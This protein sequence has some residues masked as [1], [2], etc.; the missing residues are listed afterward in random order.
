[1]HIHT[2]H[3][4]CMDIIMYTCH[5]TCS[6]A[7]II[8][9][10]HVMYNRTSYGSRKKTNRRNG[11]SALFMQYALADS[12]LTCTTILGLKMKELGKGPSLTF[13]ALCL[14]FPTT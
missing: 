4:S 5:P 3:S 2:F 1:M 6:H 7:I 13:V 9:F 10:H 14:S 11:K 8:H 12:G